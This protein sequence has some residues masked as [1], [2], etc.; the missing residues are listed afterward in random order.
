MRVVLVVLVGAQSALG[1]DGDGRGV[2]L[3]AD[4]DAAV[5]LDATT[6]VA[7]CGDL[8]RATGDG[9]EVVG[10]DGLAVLVRDLD[11]E[12]AALDENLA[13]EL[14]V[15]VGGDVV[16]EHQVLGLDAVAQRGG[17]DVDGTAVL[18][19]V[20]ARVDGIAHGREDVDGAG[21][22]LQLQVFL[23]LDGM[24]E[25]AGDVECAGALKLDVALAV[26]TGLLGAL[27]IVGKGVDGAVLEH[28]AD[29]L[30]TLD[31]EGCALTAGERETIEDEGGLVL[32]VVGEGAI[33]GGAAEDEL[34]LVADIVVGEHHVGSAD[35]GRDVGCQG[36][37]DGDLGR[38]TAVDHLD[39]MDGDDAV[40]GGRL[41]GGAGNGKGGAIVAEGHRSGTG[42]G[43]LGGL[44]ALPEAE[45]LLGM[46]SAEDGKQHA[47]RYEL[48]HGGGMGLLDN[49]LLATHDVEAL[50]GLLDTATAEVVD[51]AGSGVLGLGL[52]GL[53]ARGRLAEVHLLEVGEHV[54]V[55]AIASGHHHVAVLEGN[56]LQGF[57]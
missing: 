10:L 41:V 22:L 21:G 46:Q 7:G 53:D 40:D 24:G 33:G 14:L 52:E 38:G 9:D 20:L 43:D 54:G 5:G 26:E 25:I 17:G 36:G 42:E 45:R 12:V 4:D 30:A 1:G 44:T 18:L 8:E 6:A 11:V 2:V 37:R 48:L 29:A 16:V 51:C 35:L 31:V 27:G 23:A 39:L 13:V 56:L 55:G 34:H 47:E 32:A 15:G 50:D 28:D 49:Y 57:Q 3:L 19:I